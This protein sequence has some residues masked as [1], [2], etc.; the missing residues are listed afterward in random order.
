METTVGPTSCGHGTSIFKEK[1]M[2]SLFN[3]QAYKV[4]QKVFDPLNLAPGM[5]LG[6]PLNLFGEMANSG[7]AAP[8]AAAGSIAAPAV[9]PTIDDAA[10]KAAKKKALVQAQQRGG[11][12]STILTSEDDK[13]G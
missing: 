2:T 4:Q 5:N 6:D 11:R 7:K 10:V 8:V 9:M 3:G 1:I 12:A 13:L